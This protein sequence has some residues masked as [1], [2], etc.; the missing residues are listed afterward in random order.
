MCT[1]SISMIILRVLYFSILFSVVFVYKI[2][3]DTLDTIP[4]F[5]SPQIVKGIF[6]TGNDITKESVILSFIGIN[7]GDY[8][9]STTLKDAE[10]QLKATRLFHDVKIIV[11]HQTDGIYLIIKVVERPYLSLDP[12]AGYYERKYGDKELWWYIRFTGA[13]SNFRGQMEELKTSIS[14]WDTRSI[15]IS[16]TKPLLPSPY[17]LGS[18]FAIARTPESYGSYTNIEGLA[19][20]T[21]S[22]RLLKTS[23]IST[24]IIPYFKHQIPIDTNKEIRTYE[25]FNSVTW[26]TDKRNKPFNPSSGWTLGLDVRTNYLYSKMYEP[27]VQLSGDIRFY[28][29]GFFS[30]DKFAFR[31]QSTGRTSSGGEPHKITAGGEGS[32]RGYEGQEIG[33]RLKYGSNV[34]LIQSEYRFPLY[35]TPPIPTMLLSMMYKNVSKVRLQ[36]NGALIADH[37]RVSMKYPTLFHSKYEGTQNGTGLGG[38]LRIFIPELE[39]GGCIDMVFGQEYLLPDFLFRSVPKWH[40]YAG[41]AF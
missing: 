19:K 13:N 31:I 24:S 34:L 8:C 40:I 33:S 39:L 35:T 22:R 1:L 38:G 4:E 36:F 10:C 7:P 6:V 26:S 32:L 2:K 21:L 12:G 18:G 29:P 25:S 20:L 5:T 15:G 16:W 14:F 3:A 41:H 27:Y 9:D 37:G 23:K 30:D 17:Y 28:L 11:N